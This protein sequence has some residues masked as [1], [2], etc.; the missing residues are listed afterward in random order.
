LQIREIVSRSFACG[1]FFVLE[2]GTMFKILNI[3]QNIG[4]MWESPT[5][6]QVANS[7]RINVIGALDISA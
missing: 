1:I 5:L 7:C 2:P 3:I 6:S 4:R